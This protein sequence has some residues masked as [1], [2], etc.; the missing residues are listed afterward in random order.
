MNTKTFKCA[1]LCRSGPNCQ[2]NPT[3]IDGVCNP[4]DMF[5]KALARPT[6]WKHVQTV[7]E[8]LTTLWKALSAAAKLGNPALAVAAFVSFYEALVPWYR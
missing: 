8:G 6:F 4:A 2:F 1:S 5:T 3:H 7:L